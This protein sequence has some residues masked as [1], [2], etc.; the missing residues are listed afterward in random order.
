MRS[1]CAVA[2]GLA[3]VGLVVAASVSSAQ[4]PEKMNYQVMLTDNAN[5]P[6]ADQAV[7]I[8]FRIYS[9][10]SGG[11]QLWAETQNVATNSIGVVSVIL[12]SVNPL[13][14]DFS[15][16]RW[17]QVEVSGQPMTP[18]RELVAAPY[19]RQAHDSSN[20]GGAPAASYPLAATLSATG[21][22]NQPGNPVDWTKLKS[23]PAGFADGVDNAGVGDGNSLDAP[24]GNPVDAL[25]VDPTGNV[26][27]DAPSMFGA[28]LQVTAERNEVGAYMKADSK[29]ADGVGLIVVADS[30]SAVVGNSGGS[31]MGY[32]V[33]VSPA[34][35]AGHGEGSA[36]GGLF[37]GH[38]T[39]DGA[40]C[41][42]WTSGSALYA[43]ASGSGYSGLFEGGA[44]VDMERQDAYPVLNVNNTSTTGWGDAA[45]FFS[46]AGMNSSTWTVYA[47]CKEGNAGRFEKHLDDNNY[48]MTVYGAT[49]SSEGLY[50]QGT[51]VSTGGPAR[52]VPTSRGSEAV[53]GVT[54]ADVD[55][56]ASGSG[57]LSG[58]A[59]RVE[60]DRLFAES[61]AG[62]T[63]VRVTA[64]PIGA[65]SA[66]YVE[67]VDAEG[68]DLTSDAGDKDV[69]FN[70][71][72]VGRAKG[73][74]RAPEISLPDAAEVAR[75]AAEKKAAVEAA[76]PPVRN[77]RPGVI[78]VRRG[79]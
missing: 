74:E 41:Y 54:A 52:V 57:R 68:F 2:I 42:S 28:R 12:G 79:E 43:H 78:E 61:V 37:F 21:T 66:L 75:I 47:D 53:F 65:W 58:G 60:F 56:M 40:Q 22:I 64:T 46:P 25:Y 35:V 34:A 38:G 30:T 51:I 14:I 9:Q 20:L 39:G 3:V 71:V 55:V 10:V 48:A 18:R 8:V 7:Q 31:L 45:W 73:Y 19:A 17:L 77:R 59:A 4:V 62:A 1:P 15:G 44:G 27:V 33:P 49:A 29:V 11:S 32:T 26:I 23:V 72:A 24:D 63:D 50:V 5:Q 67:R 13:S 16:P 76:R 36:N 6:L 70:W 69:E